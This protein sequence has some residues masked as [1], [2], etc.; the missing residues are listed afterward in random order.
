MLGFF[1][2]ISV[3]LCPEHPLRSNQNFSILPLAK[4]LV[5]SAETPVLLR[6]HAQH[7]L[8]TTLVHFVLASA[9]ASCLLFLFA[10]VLVNVF[11]VRCSDCL[12][13]FTSLLNLHLS[14]FSL[15]AYLITLL[16]VAVHFEKM[17]CKRCKIIYYKAEFLK[18]T[19]YLCINYG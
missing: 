19:Y 1:Y 2:A 5:K 15:F 7:L 14:I 4:L 8:L 18:T 10:V 9:F 11:F 3:V 12:R 6:E 16:I 17:N 13:P